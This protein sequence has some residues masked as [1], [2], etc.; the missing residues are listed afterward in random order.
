MFYGFYQSYEMSGL[1]I[2]KFITVN[3]NIFMA[4]MSVNPKNGVSIT[5][6][7]E[8]VH[9]FVSFYQ[10]YNCKMQE[11]SVFTFLCIKT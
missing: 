1:K 4:V 8:Y 10:F 7:I 11:T 6:F 5:N 9:L 2:S 3:P